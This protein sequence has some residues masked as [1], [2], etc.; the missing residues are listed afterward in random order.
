MPMYLI[1]AII[2]TN[3]LQTVKI[4]IFFTSA[5][6]V[7]KFISIAFAAYEKIN[8]EKMYIGT[9]NEFLQKTIDLDL[10]Y[11]DDTTS[12]DKFNRAFGNCCK[13]IDNINA[14]LTSLITSVLN[15]IFITGLLMWMDF[16]MFIAIAIAII[17]TFLVNNKIKKIDYEFSKPFSEKSKQLNYLYR[18]FYIPQLVREVKAN[19]LGKYIFKLKQTFDSESLQ[20][21]KNQIKTHIP[22]NIFLGSLNIIESSAVALYF[23]FSVIIG[24]IAVAE[25]FMCINAYNQLKNTIQN[26]M[27]TY[28]QLYGNS[29][30]ASDYIDFL[31]SDETI[32]LNK[33]GRMLHNIDKIKFVNVS[34][35]YPNS[36]IPAISN[37][38]FSINKGDKVAIIGKN[39]AGKTTIIK[40]LL[41]LYDPT[42]GE[43]FINDLNIKYYNTESLRNAIQTL[44]QDFAIYAFSIKDNISLG[45]NI[46]PND[47]LDALEKIGLKDKV[48]SLRYELDTPITS[49]LYADGIEL[50]G[51]EAQK[52]AIS[53]LYAN[54]PKTFVMDEP[55]SNLDPHAEYI[56]YHRLLEDIYK[57][58][59]I[60]VVSHRLT[61]TYKM[62]KI[63]VMDAGCVIEN[64]THDELMRTNGIY[65]NM[66]TIQA[67]KYVDTN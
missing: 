13:V 8:N 46:D 32:T 44:F 2:N 4:I 53:R 49:Q 24:R 39:G 35:Q 50:S 27:S 1:E 15:I 57:E 28:T 62:S 52:L 17:I 63:I 12:Y 54:N 66:Y 37:V 40:L 22:F 61:L 23:G 6:L 11:F 38:S 31:K 5:F 65:R 9:I 60:I 64:G 26:I 47:I 10:G 29:L 34:F 56:L 51:G 41:R 58:S 33:N 20:L 36:N 43:I 55:T 30:F 14:I 3:F 21:T 25:Y 45:R 42:S 67:E 48:D 16:Y 18:L 19:N 7:I 59:T